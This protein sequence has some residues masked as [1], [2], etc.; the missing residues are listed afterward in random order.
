MSAFAGEESDQCSS[1]SWATASKR[2]RAEQL[3]SPEPEDNEMA[4][5]GTRAPLVPTMQELKLGEGLRNAEPGLF[6]ISLIFRVFSFYFLGLLVGCSEKEEYLVLSFKVEAATAGDGGNSR[7]LC[8]KFNSRQC[9]V[10]VPSKSLYLS[11]CPVL[12]SIFRLVCHMFLLPVAYCSCQNQWRKRKGTMKDT[13]TTWESLVPS[14]RRRQS[15]FGIFLCTHGKKVL[16]LLALIWVA[17]SLWFPI[18]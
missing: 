7:S 2:R 17:L 6:H 10:H 1:G 11:G 14:Y 16:F 13:V 4:K 18:C 9:R 5:K 8:V 12:W 15:H 3:S